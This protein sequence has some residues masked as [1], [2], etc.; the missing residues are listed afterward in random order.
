MSFTGAQIHVRGSGFARKWLAQGRRTR[1]LVIMGQSGDS[2]LSDG[3]IKAMVDNTPNLVGFGIAA[4]PSAATYPTVRAFDP[5]SAL[6][7][8]CAQGVQL[9]PW[10]YDQPNATGNQLGLF[11]DASRTAA[12]GAG[13]G[14]IG[15]S[16]YSPVPTTEIIADPTNAM[17]DATAIVST[18]LATGVA[19]KIGGIANAVRWKKIWHQ[20]VAAAGVGQIVGGPSLAIGSRRGGGAW[21]IGSTTTGGATAAYKSATIDIAAGAGEPG[22]ALMNPTGSGTANK[23][24]RFLP[25]LDLIERLPA[26]EGGPTEGVVLIFADWTDYS[27]FLASSATA[28]GVPAFDNISCISWIDLENEVGAIDGIL[29]FGIEHIPED[30]DGAFLQTEGVLT[31]SDGTAVGLSGTAEWACDQINAIRAPDSFANGVI[32]ALA[33]IPVCY[34]SWSTGRGNSRANCNTV[35]QCNLDNLQFLCNHPN[36]ADPGNSAE[37]QRTS[38]AHCAAVS[39]DFGRSLDAF[40]TGLFRVSGSSVVSAAWAVGTNYT[41]GQVVCDGASSPDANTRW[42]KALVNN[43]AIQ[44]SSSIGVTWDRIDTRLTSAACGTLFGEFKTAMSA[45]FASPVQPSSTTDLISIL[46]R[47]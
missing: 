32:S 22:A 39:L 23:K 46:H 24:T 27:P 3:L 47:G 9:W 36:P 4:G 6:A 44:P 40:L 38:A 42:Y 41:A 7:T 30:S 10:R 15:T 14:T 35:Q 2:N 29:V 18:D 37:H 20:P 19:A 25:L 8:K 1:I 5:D 16:G 17:P 31:M 11:Y 28:G 34:V 12:G 33:D 13:D 45:P 21:T 43:I 26:A